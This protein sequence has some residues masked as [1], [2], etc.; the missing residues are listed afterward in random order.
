MTSMMTSPG[1]KAGKILQLIYLRQYVSYGVD[2]KLKISEIA[3]AIL[4]AYLTLGITSGKKV[5]C[6]LKMAAILNMLN[7]KT[8]SQFDLRYENVVPNDARKS[9]FVVMT[10]S[11]TSQGGLEVAL[12]IHD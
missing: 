4:L 10:S 8:Q 2:Q 1:H 5:C 11:M 9:V 12:C 7:Y 6:D 3:M